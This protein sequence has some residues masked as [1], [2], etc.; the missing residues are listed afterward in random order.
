LD[1][2]GGTDKSAGT[3]TTGGSESIFL[4]IKSAREWAREHKPHI[5]SP[6]MVSPRTAHPAFSKAAELLGIKDV[7]VATTDNFTVEPVLMESAITENT[8]ALVGSA[9][10][11]WHGVFDPI[12]DLGELAKARDVWLHVDACL[13][14]F[15]A[16]WARSLGRP[17][18]DFDLA[19]PGVRSLSADH[20]KYLYSSKGTS[21]LLFQHARDAGYY[22]FDWQG[23]TDISEYRTRGINGTV[24]GGP[25]AAA[26]AVM[27]VLGKKGY[28]KLT[29]SIMNTVDKLAAAIEETDGIVLHCAPQLSIL[30]I[31]SSELDINR[32]PPLLAKRNWFVNNFGSPSAVHLRIAPA[33]EAVTDEFIK[34]LQESVSA[35]RRGESADDFRAISYSD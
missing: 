17:I 21:A 9:P 14:G 4:G 11:Y 6:E 22:M 26:W 13:G 25:I 20:H 31:G 32:V 29:R 33:H 27:N 3:I 19:V 28:L 1:L 10:Q 35:V 8:I 16:P 12:V 30:S 7:R 23:A 18:P 2:L 5:K 34:D 24:S 15:L